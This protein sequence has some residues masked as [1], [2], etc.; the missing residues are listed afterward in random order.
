V[1]GHRPAL[2]VEQLLVSAILNGLRLSLGWGCNPE[3]VPTMLALDIA[4]DVRAP[5]PQDRLAAGT[6]RHNT[7]S[8][9]GRLGRRTCQ[10]FTGACVH[11][12]ARLISI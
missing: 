7:I 5:H 2:L 11:R 4:A 8:P 1:C 9:V 6:N 10:S 3:D 12:I